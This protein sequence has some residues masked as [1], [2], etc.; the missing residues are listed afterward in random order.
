VKINPGDEESDY[1]LFGK[2]L[3]QWGHVEGKL[4]NILLRLLHPR[5][6]FVAE[7]RFGSCLWRPNQIGKASLS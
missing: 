1:A 3:L 2:V 4:I 5:F 6:G 7:I